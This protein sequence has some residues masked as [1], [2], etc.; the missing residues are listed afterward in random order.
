MA[1]WRVTAL[2]PAR[3]KAEELLAAAPNMMSLDVTCPSSLLQVSV[4]AVHKHK[5][6]DNNSGN[7][8]N[9]QACSKIHKG[10]LT[11]ATVTNFTVSTLWRC[12]CLKLVWASLAMRLMVSFFAGRCRQLLNKFCR[13]R[14]S[15]FWPPNWTRKPKVQSYELQQ[16]QQFI[17]IRNKSPKESTKLQRIGRLFTIW[18]GIIH[19]PFLLI[20]IFC[21][22]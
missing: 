7:L 16:I 17:K 1:S 8:V 18:I 21:A 22:A 20:T 10:F 5:M 14:K 15:G 12:L 6:V 4:F 2:P 13:G 11:F 9:K 3:N 19:G